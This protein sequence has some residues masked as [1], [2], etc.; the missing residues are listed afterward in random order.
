MNTTSSWVQ[1]D[2]TI[3]WAVE[4]AIGARIP[5]TIYFCALV[6]ATVVVVVGVV[7]VIVV[8]DSFDFDRESLIRMR[9]IRIIYSATIQIKKQ[10]IYQ[11]TN[12]IIVEVI[13]QGEQGE[14]RGLSKPTHPYH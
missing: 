6:R 10:T 9:R 7:V 8:V 5:T 4:T 14:S 13:V 1:L 12:E 11:I 2:A 3:S